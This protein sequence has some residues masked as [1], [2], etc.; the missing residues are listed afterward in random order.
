MI[1]VSA[2]VIRRPDGCVLICQRG[3]GRHNA[4]LWEF[5]GGKREPGETAAACLTRELLE[6]LSLPVTNVQTLCVREAEGIRFTF[7]TCETDAAPVPT[8]HEAVC[9]VPARD[10]LR[11][12]FCPADTGV[13]QALALNA[14]PLTHFLW[15]F[16][17]TL[18]DTYPALTDILVK[19]C[20][21]CGVTV[22]PIRAL[23]LMKVE[24]RHAIAV[25]SA[26]SGVPADTLAA[27][28]RARDAQVP[29]SAF[30][31]IPGVIEAIRAM[32]G[33]HYLVTHRDRAAI[34]W[35]ELM[36]LA[37]L[38]AGAVTRENG[39]PRKPAPDMLLHLMA[40]QNID[41]RTAVMIG[42]R[43][44]DTA[45]GRAAGVLSCMLDTEGRFPED[46]AELRC[47]HAADLPRLLCPEYPA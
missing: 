47:D 7:L 43:P 16:D 15:D 5:P 6:E 14:P 17:G 44:L 24:L 37:P 22:D 29:V 42:D 12:P 1:E 20:A 41:P 3:E 40:E 31:P 27:A 38:F 28:V 45:A 26:E 35:L 19:G 30:P 10:M 8:E 21:D 33:R 32:H 23:A 18:A 13:A 34:A 11:Y 46:P 9:F 25:I 39:L 36:G 2:G 4:H